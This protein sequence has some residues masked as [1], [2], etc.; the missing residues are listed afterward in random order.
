M[1]SSRNVQYSHP[2]TVSL[3][4][5]LYSKPGDLEFRSRC[6]LEG[7]INCVLVQQPLMKHGPRATAVVSLHPYHV[8]SPFCQE[9]INTGPFVMR[10]T[11]RRCSGRGSIITTPCVV[12]RGAGQAKQ[13]KRV[14]IPVPAGGLPGRGL[15]RA[16]AAALCDLVVDRNS[17]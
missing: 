15:D 9:T 5:V 8:S 1:V 7:Q 2:E 6:V 11:C 16:E 12:C 4:L 3:F 10:S 13:K 17:G 14:V